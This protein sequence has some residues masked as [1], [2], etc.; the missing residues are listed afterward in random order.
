MP[1]TSTMDQM[2]IINIESGM[3]QYF[4]H[5]DSSQ[6]KNQV[7]LPTFKVHFFENFNDITKLRDE[8]KSLEIDFSQK[9]VKFKAKPEIRILHTW[10]YAHMQ[11]RKDKWQQIAIDRTRFENRIDELKEKISPILLKKH[12]KIINFDQN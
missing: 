12:K 8:Q 4:Y 3:F 10:H 1:E 7:Q 9:K 6:T 2:K 5:F 11:A